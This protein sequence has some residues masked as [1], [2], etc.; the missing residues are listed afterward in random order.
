VHLLFSAAVTSNQVFNLSTTP[1]ASSVFFCS[2]Q[3]PKGGG[4]SE[5]GRN[6]IEVS[7][8]DFRAWTAVKDSLEVETS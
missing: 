6:V 8:D 4:L 1:C 7:E 2:N 3:Q 5:E